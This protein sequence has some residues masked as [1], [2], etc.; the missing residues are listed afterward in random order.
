M[1]IPNY[2]I[3]D[4]TVTERWSSVDANL[5]P[6]FIDRQVVWVGKSIVYFI[7]N[8]R[9]EQLFQNVRLSPFKSYSVKPPL[10]HKMQ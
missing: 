4:V 2:Q 8:D 3:F 10:Q 7:V 1:L 6:Q 5:V 9:K